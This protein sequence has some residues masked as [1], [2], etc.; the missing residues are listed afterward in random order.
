MGVPGLFAW[1]RKRYSD[2]SSPLVKKKD[3]SYSAINGGDV[4][5]LYIGEQE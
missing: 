5:N 1:L 4:D 3:G 2:I